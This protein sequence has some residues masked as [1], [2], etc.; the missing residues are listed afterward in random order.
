[1]LNLHSQWYGVLQGLAILQTP[2]QL[3]RQ[4]VVDKLIDLV[5][6]PLIAERVL[7]VATRKGAN[8][9]E[10]APEVYWAAQLTLA[11]ITTVH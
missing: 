11:G 10:M 1:M 4:Q 2:A 9:I 7:S 8:L 6:D 5:S 3:D